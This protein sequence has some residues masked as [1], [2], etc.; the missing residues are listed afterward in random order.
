[1]ITLADQTA[2]A[3]NE[4][5]IV[6]LDAY[7][8]SGVALDT[9]DKTVMGSGERRVEIVTR[10]K[11]T[12]VA[13]TTPTP[14]KVKKR[15]QPRKYGDKIALYSMFS[16][17]AKFTETTMVLYGKKTR[18][19]YL[20]LD[21]IWRPVKRLIRFVLVE[22]DRGRCILISSSLTLTPEEIIHIYALRFKIE[23]SFAELK[24]DMGCFAYHFW[25]TAIPKRKK[26]KRAEEP[27]DEF[28]KPR[29]DMTRKAAD[30]FVCLG[31]IATGIL[32]FIA[33]DHSQEIWSRYPGW[34]RTRRSS[35]PT[36]ATVKSA[37]YQD[38]HAS[39]PHLSHLPAFD[40][41]APL[42]RLNDFFYQNVA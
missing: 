39:L 21:L 23:T 19:R 8:S 33:F 35:I 11:T 30:S 41:I 34:L 18:V 37:F 7:F 6:V 25:T 24:H 9:S 1:M 10:A 20:C 13:Y 4:P 31:T 22:T 14:P 36:I 26:R 17:M 2:G 12:A 40:F 15:G 42:L 5:V 32:T 16:N 38:F 28:M 29:A 27:V 3:M